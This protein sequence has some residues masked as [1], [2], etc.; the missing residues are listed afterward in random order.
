[1]NRNGNDATPSPDPRIANAL[2]HW[3]ALGALALLMLP[4]TRGELPW[5]GSGPFWLL[6][7]PAAALA[8]L[9]RGVLAA[10]WR[11]H[12]VRDTP[13][14]RRH[15]RGH[16]A[17]RRT[18]RPAASSAFSAASRPRSASSLARQNS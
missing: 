8:V 7:A 14:R 17:R 12:L 10:A 11:A 15:A 18:H 2:W 6:S 16:Q 9:Y 4:P 3:L 5:L 13:R 1:M